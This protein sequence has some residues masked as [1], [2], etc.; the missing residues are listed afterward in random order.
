M[1]TD[2]SFL[3]DEYPEKISMDQLYRICHISKRKAVWLLENGYIPCKDTG[4]K[5]RRFTIRTKDVVSYLTMLETKP[6]ALPPMP[7][8]IF[9]SGAK[10][11]VKA[12]P[13]LE[14]DPKKFA[15]FL[16]NE[17]KAVPDA[18]SVKEA[19]KLI[20]YSYSTIIDWISKGRF[21]AVL[22]HCSYLI[23][24]DALIDYL[25]SSGNYSISQKSETHLKLIENYWTN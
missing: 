15:V 16:R 9:S 10:Y 14:I 11:K 7:V 6:E 4:K 25:A 23:P 12:N 13:C 24:K 1:P 3:L 5:T 20:G 8:G 17:W 18:L 2:Y 21:H 22:Y 19:S